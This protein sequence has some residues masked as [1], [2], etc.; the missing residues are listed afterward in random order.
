MAV[1]IVGEIQLNIEHYGYNEMRWRPTRRRYEWE[2]RGYIPHAVQL[3]WSDR[4]SQEYVLDNGRII[5][6]YPQGEGE[7][8]MWSYLDNKEGEN[9]PS[10]WGYEAWEDWGSES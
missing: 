5:G 9:D 4:H 8:A 2:L 7:K 6:V 3:L 10:E 1:N